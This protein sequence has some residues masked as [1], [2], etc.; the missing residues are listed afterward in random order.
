MLRIGIRTSGWA[1]RTDLQVAGDGSRGDEEDAIGEVFG[2]E[3][4]SL[5]EGLLAEVE[6]PR[7][8]KAGRPV[9]MKQEIVDLAAMEGEAD[10]LLL[11]VGDG[12]SGRLVGGDGDEGD[13]ARGRLRALGG[14]EGKVDLFDDAE[15]G[16]GLEG[17]TVES[18]LDFGG[19]AGIERFGIQ[20]L[21]DL[22]VAVANSHREHLLDKC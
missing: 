9:L 14:E 3:Q 12:F 16:L 13:F 5:T 22:A 18:L 17:R 2:G 1:W 19:E 20:A 7:L 21:D 6:E 11:A 4:G 10:G 8:A 15:N